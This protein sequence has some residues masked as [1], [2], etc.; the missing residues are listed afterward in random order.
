MEM[1][2]MSGFGIENCLTKASLGWQCFG[3]NNKNRDFCTFHD[4]YVRDFIRKSITG[5]K[6]SVL[7]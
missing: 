2:E 3:K 5:G 4:K 6:V 1:Q 7:N